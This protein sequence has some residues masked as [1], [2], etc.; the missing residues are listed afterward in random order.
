MRQFMKLYYLKRNHFFLLTILMTLCSISLMNGQNTIAGTVTDEIGPLPGVSIL[1][2]GTTKGTVTDFDGRFEINVSVNQ[3]LVFSYIGMETQEIKITDYNDLNV[4]M[5]GSATVLEDVVVVGYG[6][7][8]K[9]S[10]VGAIAQAKG[11]ILMQSGGVTDVTQALQGRL[12]GVTT[13]SGAG[14]PGSEETQIFIRGSSSWNGNGQPLILVDGVERPMSDVD[15]NEIENISVLKDASATAVFGVQGGNGVILV[16]TKRGK[17]GKAQLSVTANSTL[18]VPSRLPRQLNSYDSFMSLNDAVIQELMYDEGAWAYYTPLQRA[19][20]Y[21]N[22]PSQDALERYP[23]VDWEDFLLKDF[24]FDHRV[25]VSARGGSAF[26]KYFGSISIQNVGDIFKTGSEIDNG[27]GYGS[28]FDYN[29]LNYRSNLDFN[30]TN[31]TKASINLAGSFATQNQ[32]NGESRRIYQGLYRVMP[33]LY[34]PRYSDGAYGY[35]FPDDPNLQNPFFNLTAVGFNKTNRLKLNTDI[36]LEQKLDFVTKGLVAKGLFSYDSY[37]TS[38]QNINDGDLNGVFKFFDA[39]GE[40]QIVYTIDPVNDFQQEIRPWEL[41]NINLSNGSRTRNLNY[42]ASLNYNNKFSE[43]HNVSGLFL[44]R[45]QERVRGNNNPRF[46]E[47]WVGRVTYNYD[48]TYFLEV[49]GAYNGSEQFARGYRFDLFPSVALGWNVSNNAFLENQDWLNKLKIRGSYGIV[50]DDNYGGQPYGYLTQWDDRGTGV[51]IGSALNYRDRSDYLVYYESLIGNP[52]LRWEVVTKANIGAEVS[53]LNGAIS[54]EFD[55]FMENRDDIFI[56]AGDRAVPN[57]VG[58]APPSGNLGKAEVKGFEITLK[59]NHTFSNGMRA[60]LDANYNRAVD[61]VIF[62]DEPVLAP[63]YTKSEGFQ[64]GQIR[65]AIPTNIMQNWDD[66]YTSTPLEDLDNLKRIGSYD[67]VDYN[68]DGVYKTID[69]IVAYGYPNRPQNNWSTT[70]GWEWKNF[71]LMAQFY[72]MYNV[73]RPFSAGTAGQGAPAIFDYESNYWTKD[74]PDAVF[75]HKSLLVNGRQ[76]P[77][78][79]LWDA[80]M[81]RLKTCEVAYKIPKKACAS[82]GVESLRLFVNGNNLLFWSDVPDDRVFDGD[83]EKGATDY[84]SFRRINFGFNLNF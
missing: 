3:T 41:G 10:V 81:V 24:A 36:S 57:F 47:D 29:R 16:T 14:R 53:V 19:E 12:P 5:I 84:P 15:M 1:I 69:D 26:A 50:G 33:Y 31:T 83:G 38:S 71:S 78:R 6:V 48:N 20:L 44:F 23:N 65:S 52:N 35:P 2:K 59:L 17:K 37:M 8:K 43:K 75:T 66:I 30:I 72:G 34:Y 11:E 28:S 62:R 45:R 76:D 46:R 74:N 73:S 49:N 63:D 80:S 70:F 13:I 54:T 55:F 22:Q 60:W 21:R 32:P 25:S 7:Q 40:E 18:K 68:G 56:S 61:K 39:N 82:L 9:E 4:T 58:I 67:I 77:F 79:N 42:Q 64:I 51:T 27:R